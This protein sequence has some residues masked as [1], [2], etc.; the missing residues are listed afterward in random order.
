MQDGFRAAERIETARLVLRRP[1]GAD[2]EA[3]FSSYASDPEVTR[4]LAWPRHLTI[5]ATRRFLEFS[6]DEWTRWPAGPYVIEERA[7]AG[8]S[9]A[10]GLA[11][12]RRSAPLPA[13]C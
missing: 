12:N 3:I 2:A 6:D 10:P 8:S 9:A 7:T 1:G 5:E 13:T 4:Y 11:S